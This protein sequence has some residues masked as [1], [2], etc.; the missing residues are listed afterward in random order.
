MRKTRDDAGARSGCERGS[1]LVADGASW[2]AR[3]ACTP[4][5]A[6]ESDDVTD[7]S[8]A[9]PL[10]WLSES[11]ESPP[12][13]GMVGKSPRSSKEPIGKRA[14]ARAATLLRST[15]LLERGRDMR[16]CASLGPSLLP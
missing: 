16:G 8:D 10:W 14:L 9:R 13:E 3:A 15:A 11:P 1:A 4:P 6:A 2:A 7:T 5:R 12:S